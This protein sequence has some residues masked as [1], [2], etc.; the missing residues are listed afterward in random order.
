MSECAEFFIT[1]RPMV[2]VQSGI[3]EH[4]ESKHDRRKKHSYSEVQFK[5]LHSSNQVCTS[6]NNLFLL[7]IN[8]Y[9]ANE[10]FDQIC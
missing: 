9:F 5:L 7:C 1:N 6:T 3:C 4:H 2:S 8:I 10:Y